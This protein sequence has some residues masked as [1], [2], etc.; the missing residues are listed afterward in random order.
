MPS[1][2]SWYSSAL[3]CVGKI[4]DEKIARTAPSLFLC[5]ISRAVS[6]GLLIR[7][8]RNIKLLDSPLLP[9]SSRTETAV[10]KD[11]N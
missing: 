8:L 4:S 11:F 10:K 6:K 1:S 3:I 9:F 7:Q 2:L 5:H